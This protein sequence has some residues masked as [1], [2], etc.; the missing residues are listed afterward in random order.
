MGLSAHLD[1]HG[2]S[3][4]HRGPRSGVS[5]EDASQRGAAVIECGRNAHYA[6]HFHHRP[7]R[8]FAIY[9]AAHAVV[10]GRPAKE[11]SVGS[12][13]SQ[14]DGSP[15]HT[16]R[17]LPRSMRLAE[18]R[19]NRSLAE[20]K[21]KKEGGRGCSTRRIIAES[22]V[23]AVAGVQPQR[24]GGGYW[25]ADDQDGAPCLVPLDLYW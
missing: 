9:E 24:H 14:I 10:A 11:G 6:A 3:N 7:K 5:R 16:V 25:L 4:R 21:K 17:A 12:R 18:P 19:R 1:V 15:A 13:S 8:L 23:L 2:I 20:K 22:R